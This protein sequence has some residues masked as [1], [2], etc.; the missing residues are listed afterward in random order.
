MC[1]VLFW[2]YLEIGTREA[3]RRRRNGSASLPC[4]LP[5]VWGRLHG[6]CWAAF[7]K[8]VAL[9]SHCVPGLGR[10]TE[11]GERRTENGERRTENRE[12]WAVK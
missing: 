8:D 9:V 4:A 3:R 6:V 11:N 2:R 12:P 1:T 7:V 5:R 10:R